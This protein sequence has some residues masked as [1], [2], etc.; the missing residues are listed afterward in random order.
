[1]SAE[2]YSQADEANR[3]DIRPVTSEDYNVSTIQLPPNLQTGLPICVSA[4][5]KGNIFLLRRQTDTP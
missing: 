2:A 3:A 4:D 1:M 5:G